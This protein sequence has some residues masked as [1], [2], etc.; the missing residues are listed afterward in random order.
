MPEVLIEQRELPRSEVRREYYLIE[1]DFQN[2]KKHRA[3]NK[4]VNEFWSE[5]T[6]KP[7]YELAGQKPFSVIPQE[8]ISKVSPTHRILFVI[9]FKVAD[10]IYELAMKHNPILLK[11]REATVIR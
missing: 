3:F 4:E 5:L 6:G 2:E 8:K 1:V 10:K 11:L 9:H 7:G